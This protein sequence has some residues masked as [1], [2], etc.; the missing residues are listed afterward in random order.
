M[1]ATAT[2]EEDEVWARVQ[3]VQ[4]DGAV[5]LGLEEVVG[6]TFEHALHLQ[7][8]VIAGAKPL[9]DK[10][11][12]A[13]HQEG[14]VH[15]DGALSPLDLPLPEVELALLTGTSTKISMFLWPSKVCSCMNCKAL[16]NAKVQV[17]SSFF[18]WV[19]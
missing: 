10:L 4:E 18:S 17:R 7:L 8:G 11:T 3:A 5:E 15:C 19:K 6:S 13:V 2:V 12:A 9:L 1:K 14:L 16:E